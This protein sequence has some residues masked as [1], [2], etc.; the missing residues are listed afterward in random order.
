[1]TF[2]LD[3]ADVPAVDARQLGQT[4]QMLIAKG[5]GLALLKGLS[6][7]EIRSLEADLW[8]SFEGSSEARLAVALRFRAL[9]QVFAA[10]RLKDLL[11][12]RGFRAISAAIEEAASQRLN[13]RFGLNVQKLVVALETATATVRPAIAITEPAEFKHA[14]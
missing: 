8:G 9:L 12:N 13:V 5:Q 6:E 7:K 3:I 1:M 14:A 2:N 10:R 4:I 11:L